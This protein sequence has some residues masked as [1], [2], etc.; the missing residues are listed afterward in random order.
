MFRRRRVTRPQSH[1]ASCTTSAPPALLAKMPA[2]ACRDRVTST[3]SSAT[4]S[5]RDAD[6]TAWSDDQRQNSVVTQ[7]CL[8]Y[9]RPCL[10][11]NTGNLSGTTS[12]T[13]AAAS[14]CQTQIDRYCRMPDVAGAYAH[15]AR[16]EANDAENVRINRACLMCRC[17]NVRRQQRLKRANHQQWQQIRSIAQ[18][19]RISIVDRL[20]LDQRQLSA[21]A[22][23]SRP[24]WASAPWTIARL[25]LNGNRQSPGNAWPAMAIWQADAR[26]P[27]V[28]LIRT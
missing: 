8:R 21:A 26:W 2:R 20:E 6:E 25:P 24:P 7:R 15:P 1:F 19:Y 11:T 5:A 12:L 13:A 16:A 10:V 27:P 9:G 14:P 18:R 23:S 3:A 4:H 17:A 28:R 22:A